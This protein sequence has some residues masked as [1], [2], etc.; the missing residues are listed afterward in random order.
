MTAGI[1]ILGDNNIVQIDSDYI[2]VA[3]RSAVAFPS[4]GSTSFPGWRFDLVEAGY[5]PSKIAHLGFWSDVPFRIAEYLP[6]GTARGSWINY[7]RSSIHLY[8]QQPGGIEPPPWQGYMYVFDSPAAFPPRY[9]NDAR[10]EIL[11]GD[12]SLAYSSLYQYLSTTILMEGIFT[13][14][15]NNGRWEY[16]IA[17]PFA[18]FIIVPIE[19]MYLRKWTSEWETTGGLMTFFTEWRWFFEIKPYELKI[20]VQAEDDASEGGTYP[21]DIDFRN[22][23]FLVAK[24]PVV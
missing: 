15:A 16:S 13:P 17:V 22:Y 7:A 5:I 10:L 12:G 9:P 2:N 14:P 18:D 3:Y 24:K 23:R 20:T 1:Q 6:C 8:V 21:G 11:R 19:N 4:K